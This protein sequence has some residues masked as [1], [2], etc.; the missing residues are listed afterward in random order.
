MELGA[1]SAAPLVLSDGASLQQ[2][3]SADPGLTLHAAAAPAKSSTCAPL[4]STG[5]VFSHLHYRVPNAHNRRGDDTILEDVTGA[6][7]CGQILALMGGSGSGKTSL[8][9]VLAQRPL[10]NARLTGDIL[11]RATPL[12]PRTAASHI[13]YVLQHDRL[14]PNLTVNETLL[15]LLQLRD[16][17]SSHAEMVRR[18]DQVVRELNLPHVADMRIGSEFTRGLSGGERRRV[19]IAIGTIGEPSI[20][21]LDEPTSGLDSTT[22]FNIVEAAKALA[23]RGRVVVMSIHQPASELFPLFDNLLILSLGRVAFHGTKEQ[24]LEHFAQAGHP[25]PDLTNPLDHFIDLTSI[26]TRSAAAERSSERQVA[27]LIER[28]RSSELR[29]AQLAEAASIHPQPVP[30]NAPARQ[31][32]PPA[33]IVWT[34]TRRM[35]TNMSR[36]S[37]A[38]GIRLTQLLF[39]GVLL[40]L[41]LGRLGHDQNS[42]QNRLGILY[43][44]VAGSMFMGLLNASGL[45]PAERE[46]FAREVGWG[47]GFITPIQTHLHFSLS[48]S[49]NAATAAWRTFSLQHYEGLYGAG[50][51]VLAHALHALPTDLISVL[52]FGSF[53]YFT[54]G[55]QKDLAEFAI[56]LLSSFS[57]M[58]FGESAGMV[59]LLLTKT[60]NT[61]QNVGSLFVSVNLLLATGLLRSITQMPAVLR[62]LGYAF[63]VKYASELVSYFELR[64][65]E[66]TCEPGTPC[67]Y[68]TGQEVIDALFP[69]AGD[70]WHRNLLVLPAFV[71]AGR[72]LV[73]LVLYL[74]KTSR[75]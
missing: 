64:N 35:L 75:R 21:F 43:Q 62:K 42:V 34:L 6:A 30:A 74:S 40:L 46:V 27:R 18:R 15:Y 26:D 72:L 12:T 49:L 38:I 22:A 55:L 37:N 63:V 25:C 8:L 65:L 39:F 45:F 73:W 61:G 20:L 2:E 71:V 41:F 19:S 50:S 7:P 70:R 10:P 9:D 3:S 52:I 48:L 16:P 51:F 36:D 29:A 5:L 23:A 67:Q 60:T 4:A 56:F 57:C 13:G 54:I 33:R 58:H 17:H 14:L 31:R 59:L 68:R 28:F 32:P 44:V 1:A 53:T 47:G 69:G 66:F 11:F 24:A